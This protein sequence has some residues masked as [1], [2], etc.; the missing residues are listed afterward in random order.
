ME[1]LHVH[2][3]QYCAV[4]YGTVRVASVSGAVHGQVR[5]VQLLE[6]AEPLEL[7][8]AANEHALQLTATNLATPRARARLKRCLTRDVSA[9][10]PHDAY[11]P[12]CIC[13]S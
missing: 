8:T 4:M 11:S 5:R 1:R 12:V 9:R 3:V 13:A 6:R 7:A 10:N 2:T